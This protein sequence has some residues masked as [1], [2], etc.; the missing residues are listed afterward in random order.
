M[1][2]FQGRKDLGYRPLYHTEEETRESEK[3]SYKSC[4]SKS[5]QYP[6]REFQTKQGKNG[7]KIK[8]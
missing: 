2:S 5:D 3:F 1:G 7:L 8:I 4:S 6:Q